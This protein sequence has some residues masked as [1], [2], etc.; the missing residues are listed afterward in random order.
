MSN[1]SETQ[2]REGKVLPSKRE[3]TV[4]KPIINKGDRLEEGAKVK[5][6][7]HQAKALIESGHIKQ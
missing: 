6:F 3:Y 5:L 4:L 1:Q 7:E 2:A